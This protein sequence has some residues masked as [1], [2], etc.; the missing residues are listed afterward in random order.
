[1]NEA[2]F[3]NEVVMSLKRLGAWAYKIPDMPVSRTA[4]MQFTP[5]RPF[6][7]VGC[8]EGR[9]F[10]IECKQMKKFGAFGPSKLR[11][12]QMDGLS[13]VIGAQGCAYVFLNVRTPRDSS[14]GYMNRLYQFDWAEFEHQDSHTKSELE[15]YD[16][17]EGKNG[18]FDLRNFVYRL[19]D[20]LVT[21]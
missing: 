16:Y 3:S 14:D 20:T 6:D 5:K 15:L 21:R 9:F 18:L 1:M 8:Y 19:S 13:G 10:A 4:G 11:P 2:Q 12:N 7:I 17:L